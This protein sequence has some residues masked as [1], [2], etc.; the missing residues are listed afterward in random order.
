MDR[1][2]QIDNSQNVNARW[3]DQFNQQGKT[4]V[5][6][7]NPPGGKSSFSLG[8]TEPEP[9]PQRNVNNGRNENSAN[10][11]NNQEKAN[12]G[13][14]K[15]RNSNDNSSNYNDDSNNYNNNE[16]V[17]FLYFSLDKES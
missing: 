15:N 16:N 7:S 12:W 6:T 11:V 9:V 3:I 17:N 2:R 14:F 13:K 4:S 10:N 8:W 1:G 5:K